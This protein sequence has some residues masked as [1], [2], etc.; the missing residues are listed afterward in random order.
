MCVIRPI[1]LYSFHRVQPLNIDFE[2]QLTNQTEEARDM[3]KR[4]LQDIDELQ[5][6]V[7]NDLP[8]HPS[9]NETLSN[10]LFALSESLAHRR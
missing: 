4:R 9:A 6:Y 10:L 3:E 5:Q 7:E 2:L 8:K 1:L